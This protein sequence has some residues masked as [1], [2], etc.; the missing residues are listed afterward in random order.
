M[1]D[2]KTWGNDRYYLVWEIEG[3]D[4]VSNFTLYKCQKWS[5]KCENLYRTYTDMYV[6]KIIF[7][8]EKNDVSVIDGDYELGLAFTYGDNPRSYEKVFCSTWKAYLSD[9]KKA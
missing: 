4:A 6:D 2:Q 5:I 9:I 1:T 8:K 7:D 3:I